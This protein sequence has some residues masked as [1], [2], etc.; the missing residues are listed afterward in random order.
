[1]LA[2]HNAPGLWSSTQKSTILDHKPVP[3]ART[4]CQYVASLRP[5]EAEL[6]Q[7]VGFSVDSFTVCN[8]LSH[9]VCAVRDGSDWNQ[10]QGSFGWA[11]E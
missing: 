4:F 1:M 2:M 10:I 6:L 9:G 5:W 8:A 3:Y 11:M 7:F